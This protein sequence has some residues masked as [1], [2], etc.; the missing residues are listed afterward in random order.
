MPLAFFE[1][2]GESLVPRDLAQSLWSAKQMHGVA[3]SGALAWALEARLAELGRTDLVPSRL[4][5]DMFR[6]AAMAP[7]TL[8][9]T[10]VREGKRIVLIDAVLLQEGEPVSRASAVFLA[11][12][13]VSHGQAWSPSEQP[14]PPPVE[15]APAGEDPHVPFF[16]SESGWSQ[17]FT[18]HQNASRKSTWQTGVPIIAGEPNSRFT[19]VASIADATS[20]V[21]N[22]GS[23]G[24]EFINSDLTVTLARLP[25][26]LQVGLSAL[27]RV[28]H[29]GIVVGT[30]TIFD[31]SGPIGTTVITGL[32]N[33][34]RTVDFESI[35]YLDSGEQTTP[36]V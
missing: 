26:T 30:A 8:E 12:G 13:G 15:I 17:D 7:S 3:V 32:A 29:D 27:D 16:H 4:T 34:K 22:W 19:T 23:R 11:P 18:E 6:P 5:V 21:S 28:E 33:A 24:V 36:G 14:T 31:R 1:R 9:T 10:V 2:D 25:E 20:M 35:G